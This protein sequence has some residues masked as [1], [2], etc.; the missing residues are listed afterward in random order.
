MK[1]NIIDLIERGLKPLATEKGRIWNSGSIAVVETPPRKRSILWP[2]HKKD[3]GAICLQLPYTY[4]FLNYKLEESPPTYSAAF[5]EAF[6]CTNLNIYFSPKKITDLNDNLYIIQGT[7]NGGNVCG[8][9]TLLYKESYSTL[10]EMIQGTLSHYWQSGFYPIHP[11]MLAA[12]K[13]VKTPE[14]IWKVKIPIPPAHQKTADLAILVGTFK[15]L[16]P[17]VCNLEKPL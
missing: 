11:A 5:D 14:D 13:H 2:T 10:K 12:W 7:S 6:I 4:G 9:D 15:A 8:G 17:Y 1:I 3:I 16:C